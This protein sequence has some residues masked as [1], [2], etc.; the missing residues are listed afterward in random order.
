MTRMITNNLATS[1]DDM[2]A[3]QL[4]GLPNEPLAEYLGRIARSPHLTLAEKERAFRIVHDKLRGAYTE[5][6]AQSAIR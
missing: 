2:V 3:R 4:N 6:K 5:V 1:S